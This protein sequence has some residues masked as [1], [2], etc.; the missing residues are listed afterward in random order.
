[1]GYEVLEGGTALARKALSFP[2]G[3]G[4]PGYPVNVSEDTGELQRVG[5]RCATEAFGM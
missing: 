1:M 4:F 3:K 5:I 2:N